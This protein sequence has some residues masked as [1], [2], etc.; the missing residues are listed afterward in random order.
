MRRDALTNII[1]PGD[2]PLFPPLQG[3]AK[4][5]AMG[6]MLFL[7]HGVFRTFFNTR[8]RVTD[9]MWRSSQPLPYQVRAAAK[10][11]IKTIINLRGDSGAAFY[12]I[13][14]EACAK[15]GITLVNFI[16]YS[17]EAPKAETVLAAKEM[18]DAIAYPA[19]MHCK[20]GADRVGLMSALYLIFRKNV[21]VA[22]AK[23]RMLT[24]W[25]YGHM[26]Q[27]KT[28]ILDFFL[29]AYVDHNARTPM[30][31]LDW[32]MQV[33]DREALTRDFHANWWASVLTDKVLRRE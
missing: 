16:I 17:R 3:W 33:Y 14:E 22:E 30:P 7:D 23:K 10:A 8:S 31:F 6:N 19:L 24:T 2:A 12:R 21:P 20:S 4:A 27:A 1:R 11:G 25:R 9:E 32:V 26:A 13:E 5:R 28:G 18:F 15:A 29:Q